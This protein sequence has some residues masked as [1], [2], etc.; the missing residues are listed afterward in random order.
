MFFNAS[1]NM[2]IQKNMEIEKEEEDDD[3]GEMLLFYNGEENRGEINI[4]NGEKFCILMD[5]KIIVF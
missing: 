4:V 5:E 3:I 2:F 1:V